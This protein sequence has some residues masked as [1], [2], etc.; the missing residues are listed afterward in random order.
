MAPVDWQVVQDRLRWLS[1]AGLAAR[2]RLDLRAYWFCSGDDL[3]EEF[4][5]A[6]WH[7]CER[8]GRPD[9]WVEALEAVPQAAELL[10]S[11]RPVLAEVG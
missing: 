9:V 2:C 4:L 1:T 6:A 5:L 10:S 3:S 8:R 11:R 7:E